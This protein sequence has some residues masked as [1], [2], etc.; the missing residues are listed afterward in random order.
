VSVARPPGGACRG[1]CLPRA[2]RRERRAPAGAPRPP[3]GRGPAARRRSALRGSGG[4][5]GPFRQRPRFT[6]HCAAPAPP[7]QKK[8]LRSGALSE[9]L[10]AAELSERASLFVPLAA[11]APGGGGG[12][13]AGAAAAP[14][15]LRLPAGGGGPYV[16]SALLAAAVDT[17]TLPLRLAPGEPP[18]RGVALGAR[19]AGS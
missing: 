1:S 12:A 17:L 10:A 11:P 16:S 9:A 18:G 3:P 2:R 5:R 6:A 13:G 8:P 4:R 14:P 7:S 19:R 15:L